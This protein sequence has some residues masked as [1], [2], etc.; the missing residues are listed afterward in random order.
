MTAIK[1]RS[2]VH[3][4]ADWY[5]TG[6]ARL[7]RPTSDYGVIRDVR[8]P[9]R[10]GVELL[11]ILLE[12]KGSVSGIILMTSCYGWNPMGIAM[13]GG[14]F[15]NRGYR[16][17]LVSSRGTFGSGGTFEPFVREVD[18]AADIVAWM[19]EQPWFDGRFGTHGYSY[20]GFT[21]WALLMD[22]PPEHVTAVIAHAPHDFGA[23]AYDGGA[24]LFGPLLEWSFATSKQ[25]MPIVARLATVLAGRG[26]LKRAQSALPLS[27]ATK[28]VLH[29]GA[30]WFPEWIGGRDPGDPLWRSANL[31]EALERVQVP[32]LIQ[33]GWQD[34][35]LRQT[36]ASYTRLVDRGIDVALTMSPW[37]HAQGGAEGARVLLPEAV[38]WFDEHLAQPAKGHRGAP[39]KVFVRGA[40]ER[41]R[42]LQAW[43]P[44]TAEQVLYPH[45]GGLLS[46]EPPLQGDVGEFTYDP[47][48]PTPTIGGAFVIAVTPGV[49]AGYQDDSALAKRSDVLTFTSD[50]LPTP[51]EVV[52]N[53]VAELSHS[54]DNPHADVFV[55]LSE[56]DGQGRSHNISDGFVRLDPSE[57]PRVVR[58]E[59]E[60]V[61]HRFA[62]GSRIR[63]LVAGGSHPR[64]ERNL[65]TD[66]DP[67]RS[68]RMRPSHRRIELSK[69][70]IVLRV[71]NVGGN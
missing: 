1:R 49:S 36:Y 2:L 67:V 12:P 14:V 18:D 15:A 57:R 69:S 5:W 61:A 68:S 64:W 8:I 24:F 19:R 47:S 33:G 50:P 23:F 7:P 26:R 42:N 63:L 17:V 71:A 10:D 38:E 30:P 21:Q 45:S 6:Y 28:D 32:V 41:W 48:E 13:T 46:S 59:L 29:G 52:G 44:V 60:P 70:R 62:S 53:P 58:L 37:T 51:L 66:D 3:R 9:M 11:A 31:T 43:P 56:V 27:D 35:F 39:V 54:S 20:L 16:V 55:R 4:L 34:G 40:D 22:P 25:E 65:G